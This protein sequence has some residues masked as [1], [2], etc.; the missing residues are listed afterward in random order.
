[1]REEQLFTELR[2]HDSLSNLYRIVVPALQVSP[3]PSV[4]VGKKSMIILFE[5]HSC[6]LVREN[7]KENLKN[8]LKEKN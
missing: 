3:T 7:V 5:K 2:M 4:I 1:M 6:L 8:R